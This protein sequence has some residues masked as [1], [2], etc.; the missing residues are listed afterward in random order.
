MASKYQFF[1]QNQKDFGKKVFLNF[2]KY[3]LARPLKY[4]V[5]ILA[6]VENKIDFSIY[7]HSG[8]LMAVKFSF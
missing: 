7:Q 5:Q 1:I 2:A 3:K 4:Y 8:Q 6:S